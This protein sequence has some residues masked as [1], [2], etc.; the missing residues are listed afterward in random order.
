MRLTVCVLILVPVFGQ[1]S[2]AGGQEKEA[3]VNKMQANILESS[4]DRKQLLQAALALARSSQPHDHSYLVRWL[5]APE[6]LSRLDSPEEYA[7][8]GRRLRI[9]M[10]LEA[11]SRNPAHSAQA[12]LVRLA[13]ARDF[14]AVPAR[15]DF[16]I[17]YSASV[18]PAPT[19]LVH[20]WDAHFQPGDGFFN[21]TAGALVTNGTEPALH[22]LEQKLGD[23]RFEH[24]DKLSWIQT[25]I[26]SHRT[27]LPLLLWC[28]HVLASNTLGP[29]LMVVLGQVLFD[30]KP[31][32][33]FRPATVVI[34]PPLEQ[35]STEAKQTLRRIGALVLRAPWASSELRA[36]VERSLGAIGR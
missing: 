28:E 1:Q 36:G 26:Y 14:L 17:E 13:G 35:A 32:Q 22:L 3:P 10:V 7:S 23:P 19:E 31:E 16:L 18:R 12:V 20:F 30:P 27:D 33:W 29:D 4:S 34:P 21:L 2:G 9:A 25:E 5:L 6:F 11:L 24:E 8:T 15:V